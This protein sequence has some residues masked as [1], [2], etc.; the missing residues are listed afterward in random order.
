MAIISVFACCTIHSSFVTDG[1]VA[2][3]SKTERD[4]SCRER[5]PNVQSPSH[6][7]LGNFSIEVLQNLKQVIIFLFD[8]LFMYYS[9]GPI[10]GLFFSLGYSVS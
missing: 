2:I 8:Y 6:Q 5:L 9:A 10:A 1:S 4:L 3:T 7:N